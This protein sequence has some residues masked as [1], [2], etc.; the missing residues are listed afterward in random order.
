MLLFSLFQ[1]EMIDLNFNIINTQG[2]IALA[3][4][5]IKRPKKSCLN[6]IPHRVR[7]LQTLKLESNKI[8]DRGVKILCQALRMCKNLSTLCLPDNNI[9][10][11]G[12]TNV[13]ILLGKSPKLT[14]L[15]ISNNNIR[16]SGA[17]SLTFGLVKSK[18]LLWCDLSWNAIGQSPDRQAARTLAR[19]LKKN[20]ILTHLDLSMNRFDLVDIRA[21]SNALKSNHTLLGLHCFANEGTV[22][23]RG[24]LIPKKKPVHTQLVHLP[25]RCIGLKGQNNVPPRYGSSCWLCGKW[26][27]ITFEW[28]VGRSEGFNLVRRQ[29]GVLRE[30]FRHHAVNHEEDMKKKKKKEKKKTRLHDGGYLPKNKLSEVLEFLSIEMKEKD[31]FDVAKHLDRDKSGQI[32]FGELVSIVSRCLYLQTSSA[33]GAGV[34]SDILLVTDFGGTFVNIFLFSFFSFFFLVLFIGFFYA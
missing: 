15:D 29:L 3:N 11:V 9:G 20:K 14:C 28:S 23:C 7:L 4:A 17:A 8:G 1:V 32:E 22:D 12:G 21:I 33:G 27:P 25:N 31:L 6:K 19:S 5:I 13:G 18:S 16:G 2:A 10:S 24:F 30:M 26:S 34:P